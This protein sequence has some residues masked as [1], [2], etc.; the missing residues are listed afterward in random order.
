[1]EN[2]SSSAPGRVASPNPIRVLVAESNPHLATVLCWVLAHDERF[3]VVA[4]ARDGDAALAC[5]ADFDLAL[6]DLSLFGLGGLGTIAHLR[7]RQEAP[8]IV[9]L[10]DT[11]AVY[12]RHAA[13]AE[14]ATGYLVKPAD[15]TDLADKLAELCGS[16]PAAAGPVVR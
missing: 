15:L 10:A 1:M 7:E 3:R 8:T 13:E 16:R 6:V 12:L 11:D 14:G 9:V 4:Q 2:V 5:P